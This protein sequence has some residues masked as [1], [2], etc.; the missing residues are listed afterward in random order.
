MSGHLLVILVP[1]A[2]D[3][4]MMALFLGPIGGFALRLRG[5]EHVASIIFN[6]IVFDMCTL[7]ATFRPRFHINIVHCVSLPM[8]SV[9]AAREK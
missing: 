3:E 2:R 8:R 1:D 5:E 9:G 7:R 4:R 6:D